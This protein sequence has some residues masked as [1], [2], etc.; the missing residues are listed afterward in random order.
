MVFLGHASG[1]RFFELFDAEEIEERNLI[2][3][4]MNKRTSDE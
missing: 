1:V 4:E 3:E 2:Y